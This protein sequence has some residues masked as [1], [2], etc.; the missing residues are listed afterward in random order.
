MSRRGK[1]G[2]RR[3]RRKERCYKRTAQSFFFVK[4]VRAGTGLVVPS[5]ERQ[6]SGG[7]TILR[8]DSSIDLN[9]DRDDCQGAPLAR[10]AIPR[11][12]P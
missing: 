9:S 4:A 1:K 6:G 12:F 11:F 7:G 2:E 5:I 3:Q 8:P 10:A